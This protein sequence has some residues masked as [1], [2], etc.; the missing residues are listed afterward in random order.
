MKETLANTSA[1]SPFELLASKKILLIVTGGIA[2]YK[3]AYLAR[4]LVK[5][6]AKLRT[7]LTEGGTKFITPLSF[8]ALT[9]GPVATSMWDRPQIDIEHISWAQWADIV[10]VAPASANFI[11]KLAR[12]FACGLAEATILAT[13]APIL[14]CPAMNTNMYENPATVDNLKLLSQRGYQILEADSGLLACGS[15]GAGRLPEPEAILT[16]ALRILFKSPLAG[17]RVLVSAGATMEAWDS[18]R[19]LSNRS[20]GKMGTHLALCSWLMGAETQVVMGPMVQTLGYSLPSYTEYRIESTNDLLS[21]MEKLIENCDLLIMAAAPADF[22]PKE[23]VSG[24]IK[25][26]IPV[27]SLALTGNPDI[28]KTLHRLKKKGALW[29][30]FAAE[31]ENL[32]ERGKEKLIDKKLDFIVLNYAHGAKSAFG[33]DSTELIVLNAQGK[34]IYNSGPLHKFSAAWNLLAQILKDAALPK[35]TA[36]K[37]IHWK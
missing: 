20:S 7:I 25:K 31:S 8:E 3:A 37:D 28:L 24:K 6:G 35:R 1:K 29:V 10:I 23:R 36:L 12:G 15:V 34:E 18:I 5:A 11:A 17:Y 33:G 21:Q 30:G 27:N 9:G 16:T 4:S 26:D 13:K 2:A 19:Y 22:R 14:I 32:L